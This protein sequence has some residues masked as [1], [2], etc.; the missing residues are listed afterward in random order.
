MKKGLI[1][2]HRFEQYYLF[3]TRRYTMYNILV[4]ASKV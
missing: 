2:S 1:D 4:E 3:K